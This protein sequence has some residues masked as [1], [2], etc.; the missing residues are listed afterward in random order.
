MYREVACWPLDTPSEKHRVSGSKTPTKK[1][2]LTTWKRTT[3]LQS[4]DARTLLYVQ[5]V[6]N[7]LTSTPHND[8]FAFLCCCL[9][10]CKTRCSSLSRQT[11]LSNHIIHHIFRS[12]G[13]QNKILGWVITET[14]TNM[15]TSAIH[16]KVYGSCRLPLSRFRGAGSSP[17]P[18][19]PDQNFISK[20]AWSLSECTSTSTLRCCAQNSVRDKDEQRTLWPTRWRCTLLFMLSRLHRHKSQSQRWQSFYFV[21]QNSAV[22]HVA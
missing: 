21:F 9:A 3:R 2:H 11:S 13:F 19:A 15:K 22:G 12:V 4:C 1:G 20:T 6:V 7:D 18:V 10:D 8:S 14:E 17:L 16:W 5:P